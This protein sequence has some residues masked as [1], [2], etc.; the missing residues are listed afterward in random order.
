MKERL[1]DT[2][3]KDRKKQK[4]K[5]KTSHHFHVDELSHLRL[6]QVVALCADMFE[7]VEDADAALVLDL[8][9]HAVDDD[10]GSGAA[11]SGAEGTR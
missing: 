5:K 2:D 7:K 1:R 8:L 10:V 6:H 9:Q 11:H 3:G 4:T